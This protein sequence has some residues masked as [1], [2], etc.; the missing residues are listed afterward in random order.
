MGATPARVAT[1]PGVG[2]TVG[3]FTV[4][5]VDG[6]DVVQATLNLEWVYTMVTTAGVTIVPGLGG[7]SIMV[8]V[9]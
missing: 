5:R 1:T 8:M 3:M 7:G 9:R 6:V 4:T 2:T